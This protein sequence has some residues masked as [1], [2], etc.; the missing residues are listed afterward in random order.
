MASIRS[1][2]VNDIP[3]SQ[4]LLSQ[5]GYRLES[6][7]LRRRYDAVAGATG[8]ALLVA[9]QDGRIVALCHVYARS[10][11]DKPPEA[12]VQ[13]LVV[14]HASRGSG[15]GRDMMTMAETWAKDHGLPSVA[16]YSNAV[17]SDAHAFYETIGYRPIATSQLFRKSLG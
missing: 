8:H 1:M 6:E 14:D 9:E 17:R 10:A 2:T 12:V 16:L 5:L 4:D 13:A 15:I 11:L 3:A 7:E